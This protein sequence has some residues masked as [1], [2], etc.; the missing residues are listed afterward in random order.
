[1]DNT[2]IHKAKKGEHAQNST[3][4]QALNSNIY[5]IAF[6]T[7][8]GLLQFKTTTSLTI[9]TAP[10]KRLRKITSKLFLQRLLYVGCLCFKGIVETYIN[11]GKKFESPMEFEPMT[12]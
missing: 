10:Y 11:S 12:F 8:Y 5:R 6:R 9:K 7:N 3:T 1:M 2:G 4:R